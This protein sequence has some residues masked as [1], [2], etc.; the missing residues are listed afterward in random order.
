MIGVTSMKKG[1]GEK[2]LFPLLKKNNV[3]FVIGKDPGEISKVFSVAAVPAAAI[4]HEGKIVWR[5]HPVHLTP[6]FIE[7]RLPQAVA[8]AA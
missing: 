1:P 8:A 6:A 4:V 7:A 3:R 2:A 5:G